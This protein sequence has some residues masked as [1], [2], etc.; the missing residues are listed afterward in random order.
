MFYT[1]ENAKDSERLCASTFVPEAKV[2][3][4]TDVGNALYLQGEVPFYRSELVHQ[5]YDKVGRIADMAKPPVE[6]KKTPPKSGDYSY[7]WALEQP[8]PTN[9][10]KVIRSLTKTKTIKYLDSEIARVLREI[11]KASTTKKKVL[12][13]RLVVVS[14]AKAR[15]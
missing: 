3:I 6:V 1:T 13:N 9:A 4:A 15:K 5:Y 14:R 10:E 8:I 7:L 12:E 2:S 11:D